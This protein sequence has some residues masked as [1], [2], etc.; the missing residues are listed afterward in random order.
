MKKLLLACCLLFV[1][2]FAII[3]VVLMPLDVSHGKSPKYH[4]TFSNMSKTF[5]DEASEKS[6][7]N[8][9]P[10][11]F[12][13]ITMKLGEYQMKVDGRTVKSA[14]AIS[15]GGELLLPIDDLARVV[16]A[17]VLDDI[18]SYDNMITEV[19]R[20][21]AGTNYVT[22]YEVEDAL[23]VDI[24]FRD[25]VVVIKNDYQTRQVIVRTFGKSNTD[26]IRK[27]NTRDTE[28]V[29]SDPGGLHM[30]QF[31]TQREAKSAVREMSKHKRVK[32]AEP[33]SI[34]HV[35]PVVSENPPQTA[36]PKN[37]WG[38]ERIQSEPYMDYLSTKGT[39]PEL[40]VAVVDTGIQSNH[41]FLA[42]RVR[43]DL[44]AN[45]VDSTPNAE[46]D[47][48]HGT[49]VAGTIVDNTP[50]NVKLIPIKV[51]NAWGS[52]STAACAFG[53]NHAVAKN[54]KAINYSITY[55]TNPLITEAIQNAWN[56]GISFVQAAGNDAVRCFE[57]PDNMRITVSATN[58]NDNL[59]YFSTYG[60]FIDISAPGE[61]IYSCVLNGYDIASGTS[62]AAPHVTAGVALL[63][64]EY[65]NYTVA[66]IK[67]KLLSSV[68]DMYTTG[69]DDYFGHG[70]LDMRM[71]LSN[72][73]PV[74]ATSFSLVETSASVRTSWGVN[75]YE[76]VDEE[77]ILQP[78][79]LP[80]NATNKSFTLTSSN[81]S[82][83]QFTGEKFVY[84]NG[85][86]ATVTAKS[87]S[88]SSLT[89]TCNFT[90]D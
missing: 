5:L 90:V 71:A 67:T 34:I 23:N 75:I 25:G 33:N 2:V 61:D 13:K 72:Y 29:V 50:S 59:A 7:E 47:H 22:R 66:Q 74:A 20:S 24:Y 53:I 68:V 19:R 37:G 88:N 69:K 45:G 6:M 44:Y 65:P 9:S 56:N 55:S 70:R 79:I 28:W 62:M 38:S 54:A 81:N 77:V 4:N 46:D 87:N 18:I 58:D 83:V 27:I 76:C 26:D 57:T 64:L 10:H 30:I 12:A 1:G 21:S 51:L 60:K 31:P 89:A 35:D 16:G 40:L 73:T 39:L 86:N 63:R 84:K 17:E 36:P 41:P 8:L 48:G 42:G 3:G 43:T 14:P 52:G 78:V 85:G 11:L 82:I 80:H 15:K 32:Y 49:H